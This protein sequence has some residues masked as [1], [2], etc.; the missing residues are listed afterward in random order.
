[1]KIDMSEKISVSLDGDIVEVIDAARGDVSRSRYIENIIRSSGM[2]FKALWIFSDELDQVTKKERWLVAHTSQPIGKPLHKHEGFV[3]VIGDDLKFYGTDKE[4]L[5]TINRDS[6][7]GLKV[8][9]DEAFRRLRDS[10]GLIPPMRIE[11]E[12]RTIYLFTQPVGG[13]RLRGD[14]MFRG[15]NK[16]LEAWYLGVSKE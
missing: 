7:K 11:T 16:A 14:R 12:R 8:G 3:F 10:R 6:I 15:E 2:F 9:Y 5:F 4:L 13:K 1:M